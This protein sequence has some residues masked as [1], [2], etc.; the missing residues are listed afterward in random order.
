MEEEPVNLL[1]ETELEVRGKYFTRVEMAQSVDLAATRWFGCLYEVMFSQTSLGE[2]RPNEWRV[3]KLPATM[4]LLWHPRCKRTPKITETRCSAGQ[5][6]KMTKS[7]TE[8]MQISPCGTREPRL[9][10]TRI[11]CSLRRIVATTHLMGK[12]IQGLCLASSEH[13]LEASDDEASVD[14]AIDVALNDGDPTHM[15]IPAQMPAEKAYQ[16]LSQWCLQR[17]PS[18]G[19]STLVI[20]LQ[21]VRTLAIKEGRDAESIGRATLAR[22]LQEDGLWDG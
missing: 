11:H 22:C 18:H 6:S 16:A 20:L 10:Q 15:D 8:V 2:F 1:D 4:S 13:S 3:K 9:C 7:Q 14:D 12:R 21:S 5:A 19:T 17:E